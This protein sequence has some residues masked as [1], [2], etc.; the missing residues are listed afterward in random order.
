MTTFGR[1][2]P[3]R[4]WSNADNFGQIQPLWDSISLAPCLRQRMSATVNAASA[5]ISSHLVDVKPHHIL[6]RP[7]ARCQTHTGSTRSYCKNTADCFH[8][9]GHQHT[10]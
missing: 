2:L 9:L 4:W 7:T 5:Y 6:P 8:T 1:L 3:C 10:E